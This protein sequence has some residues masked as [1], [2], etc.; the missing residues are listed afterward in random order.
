MD[1]EQVGKWAFIAGM[2]VAVLAGLIAIPMV[3]LG[4]FVLGLIVGFLNVTAKETEKF[5]IAAIAL[6]VL[7]VAS[8]QT[9][10]VLGIVVSGV[11]NAILANFTAFVG[12]SALVVAIKAIIEMGK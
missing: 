2:V 4:L 7:G 10:S 3:A 1:L 5:L 6:I 12:A 11:L 8:I 9:L